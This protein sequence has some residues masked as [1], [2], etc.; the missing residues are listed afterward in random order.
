[1]DSSTFCSDNSVQN[2]KAEENSLIIPRNKIEFFHNDS[3]LNNYSDIETPNPPQDYFA[4]MIPLVMTSPIPIGT[5][6][7]ITSG[8]IF[9]IPSRYL[10]KIPED[11]NATFYNSAYS[12]PTNSKVQIVKSY[13]KIFMKSY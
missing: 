7:K 10:S 12:A 5:N 8:D 9:P 1:M 4:T 3:V 13:P 11:T 6:S 2:S